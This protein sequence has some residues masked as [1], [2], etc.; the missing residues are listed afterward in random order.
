MIAGTFNGN[1]LT[2]A[3]GNA[4]LNYLMDNRGVYADLASKGDYLRGSFNRWAAAR[5]YPAAMTGL[6]SL[7]QAHLKPAPISKPRHLFGQPQEALHD[8]QLH[9][10]LNG[11]FLPWY[12]MAFLSTAHQNKDV[13][14]VLQAHMNAVATAVS[15][16]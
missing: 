8:L 14:L 13:E 15:P 1:P 16:H 4:L 7:F 3:A 9:L 5:G 10:R 6:G 2:V 12:H 11:L